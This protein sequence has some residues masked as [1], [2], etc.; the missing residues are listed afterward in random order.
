MLLHFIYK[1]KKFLRLSAKLVIFIDRQPTHNKA[2]CMVIQ[3]SNFL[4]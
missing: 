1:I 4:F 3:T 2:R